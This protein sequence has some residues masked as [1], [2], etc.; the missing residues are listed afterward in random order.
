MQAQ[1]ADDRLRLSVEDHDPGF[2]DEFLLKAF[3][4][5]TRAETSRTSP[6][7]GLGRALLSGSLAD[8]TPTV[9][10]PARWADGAG[11]R[12][13]GCAT[14]SSDRRRL[15]EVRHDHR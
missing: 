7:S 8:S 15:Y 6:G 10:E 3:D 14:T 9:P 13:V 11:A 1:A 5:V 4:R 12:Q 2:P